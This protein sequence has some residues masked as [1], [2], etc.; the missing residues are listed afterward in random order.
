VT[1]QQAGIK[2]ITHPAL[3]S[4]EALDRM[5]LSLAWSARLPVQG[6]RDGFLS[7]QVFPAKPHPQVLVQTFAGVATL[8]DGETG[9]QLWSIRI[10]EPYATAQPAGANSNS[11]FITRRDTLYVINRSTGRH[12]A[13]TANKKSPIFDYGL[14]LP[15]VP[16]AAPNADE[17]AVFIVMNGRVG[18][19]ALPGYEPAPPTVEVAP[20]DETP[21][22][23]PGTEPAEEPKETPKELPKAVAAVAPREEPKEGGAAPLPL[24]G[25]SALVFNG[26]IKERPL[27]SG[28]QV[29]VISTTGTLFS[30]NK[31]EYLVRGEFQFFGKVGQA[32]GQH[33]STAYVAATDST[34]Y[35][36]DMDLLRLTWRFP[37]GGAVLHPLVVTDADVF[38]SSQGDGLL[39]LRRD[40]GREAWRNREVEQ[41]LAV[42]DRFVYA[43][44]GTG[45]FFVLDGLRGTTLA[46]YDLRDWKIAVPNET[47][48]RIYLANHDGQLLCLRHRDLPTALKIKTPPVRVVAPKKIEEKKKE[49][50]KEPEK[51]DDEKKDDKKKD[52]AEK[53][54]DK[55]KADD[56]KDDKKKDDAEK[57][58]EKK[59]DDAEKKDDKKKA[60]DKKD[61][62]KK[63]DAEKKGAFLDRVPNRYFATRCDLRFD[64]RVPPGRDAQRRRWAAL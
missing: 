47:S 23:E 4:R 53:K 54:D 32:P 16:T 21:A 50:A 37:V 7:V 44:D 48:D 45:E 9:D 28:D 5:N 15:Y 8:F 10:G 64:S 22:K 51:K 56:K 17:E 46:R 63:D 43:L 13:A 29:S 60:D 35:A 19:Y 34:V 14:P 42:N 49:E 39:R 62:K 33:G 26:L 61:D 59:K 41:F 58:D 31:F 55:K 24:Q 6:Q 2:T 12:R 52:D 38:V 36:V 18:S 1:A 11:I 40:N 30:L 25:W 27:L 57:K 20:K 3:P